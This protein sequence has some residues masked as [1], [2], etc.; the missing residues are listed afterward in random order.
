MTFARPLMLVALA[1]V[2]IPIAIHLLGR[3][4]ARKVVLPT[5][6]FAEGAHQASRGRQWL[7][8]AA[9]LALRAAAVVLLVLA[10]AEPRLGGPASPHS[11][12]AGASDAAA[13]W[14]ICLDTS[15]SMLAR[16][17]GA[18]RL[19]RA[20]R[21]VRDLLAALPVDARVALVRCGRQVD[22]GPP[23]RIARA[24]EG[25]APDAARAPSDEPL[26]ALLA[27]GLAA[28]RA[29]PASPRSAAAGAGAPRVVLVTDST[30]AA[31][32]DLAPGR[33]KDLAA[34]VTI[35]PVGAAIPNGRLGLPRLAV[36][37]GASARRLWVEV[38][39]VPSAAEAQVRL[40]VAG[41]PEC[42]PCRVGPGPAVARFAL[43][44]AGDGPPATARLGGPG[45]Q[46][47]VSLAPDAMPLDDERFF[48]VPAPA[49]VRVVVVDAAAAETD[50]PRSADYV[51]AAFAAQG[52][53][54]PDAPTTVARL[55]PAQ[56]ADAALRQAA[57]VFWVGLV[58]RSEEASLLRR[59]APVDQGR[60]GGPEPPAAR[61]ALA[62]FLDRGGAVISVPAAAPQAAAP[63]PAA[64]QDTAAPAPGGALAATP[65][66]GVT[67][68][69][70]GYASPL[71]GA[72]EGGSGG[73]LRRPV[74]TRRLALA[75]PP[76]ADVVRFMD[77]LPAIVSQP[78]GKGRKVAL[79]FGPARAWGDLGT[80]PEFV[81]LMHS[82]LES[83]APSADP[84]QANLVIGGGLGRAMAAPRLPPGNYP[85]PAA[86]PAGEAGT[87]G[88]PETAP[89]ATQGPF[90]VNLAPDETADLAPRPDRVRQAFA[91]GRARVASPEDLARGSPAAAPLR[92]AAGWL[93]LL[94]AVVAAAEGLLAARLSRPAD[95]PAPS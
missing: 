13:A 24:L 39:A 64:S 86:P 76:G 66:D 80:R 59:V 78:A 14:L 21:V 95:A 79:A 31:A 91:A 67:L 85:P 52:P 55:A 41:L 15:P 3:R 89:A 6:R 28:L 20:E 74:F 72:F 71:L 83:L 63:A 12:M 82:L 57:L 51:A 48:T 94:L 9:L 87:A 53:D 27:R 88:G 33:F 25:A 60:L 4:R 75:A 62:R 37:G 68:D 10:L 70:G 61:D 40:R 36:T 18:T 32:R 22:L 77:G 11:A 26:G 38:D 35:V 73:D 2:A 50:R 8:R 65:A 45:W 90:S 17:A 47:T 43:A 30:A 56:V 81:V 1:A 23:P 19:D 34:D 49:A 42:P 46:G 7:R 54:A 92:D 5:M 58:L 93:I 69:P 84:D 29:G 16:E 44:L